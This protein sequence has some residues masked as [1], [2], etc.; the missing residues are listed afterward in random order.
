MADP[1]GV[2][3]AF[4]A[5]AD[6]HDTLV[7]SQ[8][9]R[10]ADLNTWH[11]IQRCLP[12][13][14]TT[15]VL[16]VGGGNAVWALKVAQLNYSVVL[17]DI[18]AQMLRRA[19]ANIASSGFG[20]RVRLL[21]ADAHNLECLPADTFSPVLAVGD[22]L[23]YSYDPRRALDQLRR[24]CRPD[25]LIL[26]TVIGRGGLARRLLQDGDEMGLNRLLHDGSWE[27]RSREELARHVDTSGSD[28][29]YPLRMH[30]FTPGELC[31][32]CRT[33]GLRLRRVFARGI[34]SSLLS[35]EEVDAL[36]ARMGLDCVLAWELQLAEERTLLGSA[37]GLGIVAQ[38]SRWPT[39]SSAR[40]C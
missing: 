8:P 11:A 21:R 7:N 39:R 24:V 38:K 27:E 14:R 40:T 15:P 1:A 25:G 5:L 37:L 9:P 17:V 6:A 13:D 32:L 30:A 20:S 19:A 16:D 29:P 4:D 33:G 22:V 35:E 26:V 3:A 36:V 31:E 2:A 23:N 12:G 10:L 28:L 18:S 34:I